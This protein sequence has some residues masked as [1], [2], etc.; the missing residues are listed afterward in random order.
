MPNSS[1]TP[2]SPSN[3]HDFPTRVDGEIVRSVSLVDGSP[4][5]CSQAG[6]PS[7]LNH[8]LLAWA[9]LESFAIT[10]D[11]ERLKRV[12]EPLQRYYESFATILD[13]QTGLY[14][15][16]WTSI[17]NSP[18]NEPHHRVC[19]AF[20]GWSAMAPIRYFIEYILGLRIDA[21]ERRLTW[22]LPEVTEPCGIRRLRFA[23]VTADLIARPPSGDSPSPTIG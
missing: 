17:D 8:P 16:D 4:H 13:P 15:A 9:E 21:P 18:R 3:R 23:D 1:W 22:T 2:E 10:A 19:P 20:T 7:S 14:R 5:R 6:T 11:I 12:Y